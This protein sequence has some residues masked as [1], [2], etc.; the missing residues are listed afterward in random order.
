MWWI[1]GFVVAGVVVVIVAALGLLI[2]QQA[3]RIRRL[4]GVAAQV[5]AEIDINTRSVWSLKETREVADA[6][7][8]G[9]QAIETNANRIAAAVDGDHRRDAA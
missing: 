5:V 6:L 7:L 3:L 2:L 4:A 8:E 1:V 9:A